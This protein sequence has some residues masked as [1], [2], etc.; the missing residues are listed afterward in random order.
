MTTPTI[1]ERIKT[2]VREGT[3]TAS[4]IVA[5]MPGK[6][7][8]SIYGALSKLVT[9]GELS[10]VAKGQ[11]V[12]G[13]QAPAEADG[14]SVDEDDVGAAKAATDP[15]STLVDPADA[16]RAHQRLGLQMPRRQYVD[17]R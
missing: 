4:K 13:S 9:Q 11:F 8:N 2:L 7:S 12:V 6:S 15:F 16:L 10:R 1:P 5:A 14:D 3:T 17:G